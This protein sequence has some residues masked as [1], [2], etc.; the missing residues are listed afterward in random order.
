MKLLFSKTGCCFL[1][2]GG[3]TDIQV[4]IL[5]QRNCPN[6]QVRCEMMRLFLTHM[7]DVPL[8]YKVTGFLV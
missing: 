3:K 4:I 5:I 1:A 8:D 2:A 7:A 6:S